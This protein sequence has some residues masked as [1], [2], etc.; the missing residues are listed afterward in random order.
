MGTKALS[1]LIERCVGEWPRDEVD[2]AR[3]ELEAIRKAAHAVMNPLQVEPG[4][5]F[6]AR[7]LMESIA[8]EEP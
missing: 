1:A 2:A 6:D 5:L 4:V 3:A 8:K 7:V